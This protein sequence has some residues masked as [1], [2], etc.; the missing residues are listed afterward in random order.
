MDQYCFL[1]YPRYDWKLCSFLLDYLMFEI[2]QLD[3]AWL[4]QVI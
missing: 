1:V 2:V 3:H 4:Y